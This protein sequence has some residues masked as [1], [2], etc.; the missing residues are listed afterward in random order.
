MLTS[1]FI[2]EKLAAH[3]KTGDIIKLRSY[4]GEYE[5][6]LVN[7]SRARIKS[8]KPVVVHGMAYN[9]KTGKQDK[10]FTFTS[11]GREIDLAPGTQAT[12]I[13]N[14]GRKAVVKKL[15]CG[16]IVPAGDEYEAKTRPIQT[17]AKVGRRHAARRRKSARRVR[18]TRH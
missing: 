3:M 14:T 12:V 10:P 5:V 16:F 18:R 11:P 13:R 1:G 9:P 2:H 6:L 4:E 7:Y 8:T 15:Y 17:G